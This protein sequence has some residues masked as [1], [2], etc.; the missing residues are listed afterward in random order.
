VNTATTLEDRRKQLVEA[1]AHKHSKILE[2]RHR[3]HQIPELKFKE[4]ETVRTIREELERYN[5]DILAPMIE[6]DTVAII[7]GEK[8]G[9]TVALRA[10]IDALP[11][12]D[13]T[14]KSWRS[15]H[16]GISH[17]CG[18]DG[19]MAIL[20]G[21]VDV[22]SGLRRQL[23]GNILCIFQPAEEEIGGGKRMMELGLFDRGPKPDIIFGLHGWPGL[24][25]GLFAT[26]PGVMMAGADTFTITI[27]G[28]GGHVGMPHKTIDPIIASARIISGLKEVPACELNP[29]ESSIVSV[30]SVTA[31]SVTNV[32][33]E[34]ST[35]K[36]AV[37]YFDLDQRKVIQERMLR[38]IRGV[39]TSLGTEYELDHQEGYIPLINDGNAVRF[40]EKVIQSYVGKQYWSSSAERTMVSEDFSHYLSVVPGAFFCLGLGPN[41]QDLHSPYFDFND[42]ALENG[43]LGL[44]ALAVETLRS[45]L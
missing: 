12:E 3:L 23:H 41:S 4:F 20:L 32:V 37:R 16:Q 42:R 39:C 24:P 1:I 43:V 5:V 10:D 31:G 29:L 18:H 6:T 38:V 17:S 28:K 30:C 44:A 15:K 45:D 8:P 2:I 11:N 19:H 7:H 36:G 35:L 14:D 21:V 13:M 22:L 9:K 34:R 25:T 26:R 27:I 33:P 40:A